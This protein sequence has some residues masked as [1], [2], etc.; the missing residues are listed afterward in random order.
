MDGY[1]Y[2]RLRSQ[3]SNIRGDFQEDAMV[4][5]GQPHEPDGAIRPPAAWRAA[6]RSLRRSAP[7][8]M[9]GAVILIAGLA[10]A[11]IP[12]SPSGL[13][14]V[15]GG[16][17]VKSADALPP[18]A[19]SPVP[20]TKPGAAGNPGVSA[21][22]RLPP[23][24]AASLVRWNAGRG[25]AALAAV[26]GQLGD[27]TQSAGLKLFAAMRRA[28]SKLAA[29]V[30]A[31]RAGPPIPDAAMQQR[32]LTSLASL[33]MGAGYCQAGIT[34][35]PYGDEAVQTRENGT[36]LGRS[37]VAFAAG[38]GELYQATETIKALSLSYHP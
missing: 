8:I 4:G 2:T 29:A 3:A 11:F 23:A 19:D 24:V 26:S 22:P 9:L 7:W 17:P 6:R 10:G 16:R 1:G 28:C 30:S 20:P 15:P 13:P 31:A 35:R 14:G 5:T 32:Y 12:G 25:G 36:A 21:S 33:A 18:S 27:A 38:A 34:A 37:M